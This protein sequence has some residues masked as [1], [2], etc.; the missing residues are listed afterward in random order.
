MDSSNVKSNL[1]NLHP[2]IKQHWRKGLLGG[3]LIIFT[4]ILSFPQPLITRYLVDN[5][6]L[7]RQLSLLAGAILLLVGIALIEKLVAILQQFYFSRF[8]QEVILVKISIE[9]LY[10][11]YSEAKS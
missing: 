7:G 9:C 4:S 10:I 8:E 11:T 5:V 3:L 2:F 1:K 6:I